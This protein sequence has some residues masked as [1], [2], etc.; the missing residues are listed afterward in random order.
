MKDIKMSRKIDITERPTVKV[1]HRSYQPSV[2]ELSKDAGIP[3]TPEQL[4]KAV[5][6]DA[7]ILEVKKK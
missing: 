6:R 5:V 2:V 7:A 4:V 1:R 3:T